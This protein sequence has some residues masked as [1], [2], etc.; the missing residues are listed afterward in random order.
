MNLGGV[1]FSMKWNTRPVFLVTISCCSDVRGFNRNPSHCVPADGKPDTIHLDQC[2]T[3][4]GTHRNMS[5][6]LSQPQFE[7][8]RQVLLERYTGQRL[9]YS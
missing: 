2:G 4:S 7:S 6:A 3:A 8:M 9:G 1:Y 5:E